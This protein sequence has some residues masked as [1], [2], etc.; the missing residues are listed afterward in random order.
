V[1]GINSAAFCQFDGAWRQKIPITGL[2]KDGANMATIKIDASTTQDETR[3]CERCAISFLYTSEEQRAAQR[4]GAPEPLLCPGCRALLPKAGRERGAVKW[5]SARKRYGFITRAQ[6]G[7]L[8]VPASSL[9]GRASLEAGD[10]VEFGLGE[11]ERGAIAV[12]VT[13]LL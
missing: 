6:K 3:Y 1:Y 7:D 12:D 2:R 11:N 13:P 9:T 4:D 8:F 5:Y 10:L